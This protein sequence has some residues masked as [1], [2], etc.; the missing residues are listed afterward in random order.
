MTAQACLPF[1]QPPK[2]RK[3][4]ETFEEFC[5]RCPE[6]YRLLEGEALRMYND[7]WKHYG[8][9]KIW[10]WMRYHINIGRRPED[11]FKLNDHFTAKYARLIMQRNPQLQGFFEIRERRRKAA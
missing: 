3:H 5:V 7:G 10:E 8:I 1:A 11:E 4:K 9:R 6:V 2:E